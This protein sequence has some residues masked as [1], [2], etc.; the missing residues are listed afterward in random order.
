MSS[1]DYG[2]R[3]GTA[4]S[5]CT[6]H[7][8]Y[9]VHS[10]AGHSDHSSGPGPQ[11][12]SSLDDTASSTWSSSLESNTTANTA[13]TSQSPANLSSTAT[14]NIS[15]HLAQPPKSTN[16]N[17][18][19]NLDLSTSDT[20]ARNE[21]LLRDAVFP[22][23]K[24]DTSPSD[25]ENPEEMQKKDPLGTQIWKLYSRT[26]SRLPNQERM[27]NLTWRMM[28]MNLRR[29]EQ[30]QAAEKQA[31]LKRQATPSS[32]PSGIAQQLRKSIDQGIQREQSSD[33]MNLDEFIVPSSVASPAGGMTPA[34]AEPVTQ[35]R[36]TQAPV[37]PIT[38][39]TKPQVHIPKNLPPSSM[40]QTSIPTHRTSEFDYVR[41][42]VRKTSIDER[43]GGGNRK[44]PADFS[45]QVP[46]LPGPN[47]SNGSEMDTGVP[48]YALDQTTA[49]QFSGPNSFQNPVSLQLDSF[50]LQEDPILTS[51]GPF[52]QNFAF[53]PAA[54][55]MVSSGPFTNGYLQSSIP[56]SLNSADFYSP[57]QSGYPS[58]VSTPQ[59]GHEGDGTFYFD[60]SGHTRTMPFYPA[61]RGTHLM[62]PSA[63]Q[64]GYGSSNEQ[65]YSLMN[66]VGSAPA[67]NG[68]S[69]Q[70]HVDPSR[71]LVPEYGRRVSPGI[72]VAGNDNLF[73][74]GADSD[75]EDDDANFAMIQSEYAQLN[76]PTLDLNSGLPWDAS[77][78]DYGHV[79]RFGGPGKQVRIG[80]AEM[81]NSPPDWASSLL[82]RTHGSAAS[83]SDI[84]NRD[85][86]P[87][88][89]KIPRTTSTPALNNQHMPSTVSSPGESGFSSRQPSRP[90]SPGPK[91]TDQN[92]V[93]TTCTNCFTQ[94]TP[95]WRRNPEGHPLCNACGLFL[96]LHGVVR[97]LSLKTDVIKKRNRG[98]GSTIPMGSAATR[99][100]KKASRKNSVQQTPV[101]TPTSGNANSEQNSAS[102]A[103]VQ[104][105]AHSGSA[106]TTPTSY[107]PGIT[108]GKPGVV[109]IAAA[110]PKPPVQPGPN[111]AR[112]V[113]V[114]PKRQRR[115][116]R[117]STNT[118]PI[119]GGSIAAN[120]TEM[121]DASGQPTPK[122]AQAP[123]TR[124]KTA[125]IPSTA[126]ATTM[127]SVMQGG[128]LNSGVHNMGGTAHGNSQEWEWLTMSL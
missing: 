94:T 42:R 48:D 123:V 91:N 102:P 93:P 5:T 60:Q 106:V 62:A 13:S 4:A 126:G 23:W 76:D 32:A 71:V 16:P 103:S 104:G 69:L 100:S 110:P 31:Q 80:G 70:Q 36:N 120:E 114:T 1:A 86:D 75:G 105:S 92:G 125:S 121:Q 97:P 64:F 7:T 21:L 66:G 78:A 112:P 47:A 98:S 8:A 63:P 119:M 3:G 90:G 18:S 14:S 118:L 127:A 113:Q 95:L 39:R 85:Q 19:S 53:S 65:V 89:Q 74:F 68:F 107:P 26:K 88:R 27:E 37:L 58:A 84:R 43:R 116:S 41:K 10:P 35:P 2:E 51:A 77:V 72:S 20:V 34:T 12:A 28:A 46:P 22:E 108:G 25:I 122:I 101:T 55:P 109:P 54:S 87:R 79:Q 24:D 61:H 73:Q 38:T 82:S 83:I 50:H 30:Q 45:P 117:A 11:P 111:M 9:A 33:P 29:R 67:A 124:S 6:A 59:P 49:P 40:P 44:R 56:S 99:A 17:L 57:P 81:V 96:K 128:L 52:Q 115:Q 15:S